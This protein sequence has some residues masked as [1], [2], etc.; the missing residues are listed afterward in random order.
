MSKTYH[1]P[2]A[3]CA[4]GLILF[5]VAT[6]TFVQGFGGWHTTFRGPGQVAVEIPAAGDYRLWHEAKTII[7]GRVHSVDDE[8]PSGA[9]IELADGRG[10]TIAIQPIRGSMS[11]EIGNIRRVALG[12]VEFPAADT[13]TATMTGF[14]DQ[15]QFRISEIRLFEHFLRALLF[16]LPGGLLF[17]IGLIWGIVT[18]TRRPGSDCQ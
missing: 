16:A 9:S 7:D 1:W 3:L 13:Y 10:N 17:M 8:L 12:R 5:L 6:W 11:Q 14:D 15:L 4:V 2:I 18:A